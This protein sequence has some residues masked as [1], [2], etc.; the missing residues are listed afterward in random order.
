MAGTD[1]EREEKSKH[2]V[3]F[4]STSIFPGFLQLAGGAFFAILRRFS[5]NFKHFHARIE[6]QHEDK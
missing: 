6:S 1:S 2:L 3:D 4:R 5:Y